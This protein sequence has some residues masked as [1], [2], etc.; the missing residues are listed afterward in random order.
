[1]LSFQHI[2]NIKINNEIVCILFFYTKSLKS[3]MNSTLIKHLSLDQHI[4]SA[5]KPHVASAALVLLMGLHLF[6][7]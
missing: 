5:P 4:S 7:F 6:K 1:M 3:S 2:I